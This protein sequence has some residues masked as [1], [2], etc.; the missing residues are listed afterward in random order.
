M[1][2]R[3]HDYIYDVNSTVAC[4]TDHIKAMVKSQTHDVIINPNYTNMFSALNHYPPSHYRLRP[5]KLPAHLGNDRRS[6]NNFPA[7]VDGVN[8]FKY[9]RRP[10]IPYMPTLGGQI[11]YA[12][13]PPPIAQATVERPVSPFSKTVAVQS[14]YR[15]SE[16]QTDPYSPEYVIPPGSVPPE[17]LALATL[18][19][20]SGLPVGMAEL[21]MIERAR[22]KRAW[23]ATL[24]KVVDQESFEKRLRMMEEMELKEWQEREEEIRKLQ[25][26]RLEIL[27]KVIKKRSEENEAMNNERVEKIWQ[28]KLQERDTL[29]EKLQKKRIKALRKISNRRSKVQNKVEKRDI[30]AEYASYGSSVYAPKARDGMYRDNPANTLKIQ[31]ENIDDYR[32]LLDLEA[33]FP[34]KI[35]KTNLSLP[36]KKHTRSPSA[37]KEKHLQEQLLLMDKKMKARRH[38]AQQEEKPLRFCQKIEKPPQRPETPTIEGSTEIEDEMEL[39]ALL[40]QGLIRGRIVQ[41]LM[42]QG[43]ERRLQLI[44]ELRTRQTIRKANEVSEAAQAA[45]EALEEQRVREG[46]EEQASETSEDEATGGPHRGSLR[47]KHSLGTEEQNLFNY[48]VKPQ[49]KEGE[50]QWQERETSNEEERAERLVESTIEAEYMGKTFDFLTKELVRLREERRIDAMV[51]LAERTRRMR[52][53]EESGLRQVEVK[54]QAE[55]DEVFRQVIKVHQETVDSY[56]EEIIIGGIEHV[57]SVQA[58]EQVYEYAG[59]INQVVDE[60]ERRQALQ[61]ETA[62]ITV[63]DL[64]SAFLIP[65][66]E[67][68][69]LRMQI[70]QEQRKYLLAAHTAVY[71]EVRQLEQELVDNAE[72]EHGNSE[73]PSGH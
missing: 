52:E 12:R 53:A 58:R 13:K 55:D 49:I 37:R 24:P 50:E 60:I 72:T 21:E 41:N 7:H 25:E 8:R 31:V 20:G 70:K 36:Q 1:P 63:A 19:F 46:D 40:L 4:H 44:G 59:K 35:I 71:N 26:A 48:E 23:E 43:K 17:L 51:K 42:Y 16:A 56:L 64:V 2:S 5:R 69:T 33:T 54:R 73:A 29:L 18:T 39:A 11:V 68:E 27:A 10:L 47:R 57:S 34:E 30:I 22:S 66:V 38:Q 14:I 28:R 61:P 62:E 65:E 15:E 45:R 67:K 9:F 6:Y 32:G 3:P